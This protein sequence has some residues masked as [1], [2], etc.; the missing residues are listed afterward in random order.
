[1]IKEMD[2][3][4]AV[5]F[6]KTYQCY[7]RPEFSDNW[8]SLDFYWTSRFGV[9]VEDDRGIIRYVKLDPYVTG[10]KRWEFFISDELYDKVQ[11]R[12]QELEKAD[13]KTVGKISV[14]QFP[15]PVRL[16]DLKYGD[17]FRLADDVY[18]GLYCNYGQNPT[19]MISVVNFEEHPDSNHYS[20]ESNTLVYKADK[21][22]EIIDATSE[23]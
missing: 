17:M 10:A 5:R 22:G 15:S 9:P 8:I 3:V 16:C 11:K 2:F 14:E 12:N 4:D 6:A 21:N 18:K 23:V 7:F 1:M 19:G 13:E 20:F